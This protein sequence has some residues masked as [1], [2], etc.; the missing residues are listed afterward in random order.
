MRK[1]KSVIASLLAI[2][3]LSVTAFPQHRSEQ[4]RHRYEQRR[5]NQNR[6]KFRLY[7]LPRLDRRYPYWHRRQFIHDDYQRGYWDGLYNGRRDYRRNFPC[8]PNFVFDYR[9]AN[10]EEYK[11]GFLVGYDKGC[12]PF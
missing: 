5:G 8:E 11:R 2:L 9:H 1:I 7:I 4:P 6:L 12:R 10:S 3:L